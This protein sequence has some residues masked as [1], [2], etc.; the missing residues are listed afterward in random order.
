MSYRMKKG[1]FRLL[2]YHLEVWMFFCGKGVLKQ[3]RHILKA[4][5]KKG[6]IHV[7][8]DA[9]FYMYMSVYVY[10]KNIHLYIS[11]WYPKK[12]VTHPPQPSSETPTIFHPQKNLSTSPGNWLWELIKG[13]RKII[14]V[15]KLKGIELILSN[16]FHKEVNWGNLSVELDGGEMIFDFQGDKTGMWSLLEMGGT[17]GS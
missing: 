15:I 9:S 3:G 11:M 14:N 10:L 7:P 17:I 12:K 5:Q 13:P 2:W 1:Y 6:G 16:A 4:P 8:Q